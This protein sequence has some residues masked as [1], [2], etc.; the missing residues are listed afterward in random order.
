[1]KIVKSIFVF[2]VVQLLLSGGH[3][4][5]QNSSGK[6]FTSDK[7]VAIHGYDVVAYFTQHEALRGDQ[8]FEVIHKGVKYWF[9]NAGHKK[10]FEENAEKYLPQYGGWCAFAMGMKNAKVPSDPKT[11]KLNDGK[12]YIFFNDYYQGQ[13]FNT[14]VP[15]N[16]DETNLK[17]KADHNWKNMKS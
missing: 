10:K 11:F 1:M 5:A 17:G 13:P 9:T 3:V 16:S 4:M 12:L 2:I 8:R 7:N 15:W 14:I 6:Q